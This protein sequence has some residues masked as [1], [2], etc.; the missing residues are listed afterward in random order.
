MTRCLQTDHTARPADARSRS[1]ARRSSS[2]ATP[3][4]PAKASSPKCSTCRR[5]PGYATGGTI[6]IIAN[7]QI[8]FTT[9]PGD[10]RSTRYASDLAKGFDVP[11]VHV[12]ADDVDACIA[13]VHLGDRFPAHVRPRRDDRSDRL[14]PLRPQRAG[15]ARVH[16]A[17]D[18][19][20]DQVASDRA[21][22]VRR[23]AGR[24]RRRSRRA[25]H[26]DARG[27]RPAR[28]AEAH[29]NVKERGAPQARSTHESQLRHDE[30]VADDRRRARD[31]CCAG[32]TRSSRRPPGFTL[33]QETRAQFERRRAALRDDGEVDWGLAE[34]LAFASLLGEGTP[35]RLT[36]QDTERGT[37]SHRHARA[38][39]R[40]DGREVRPAAAPRRRAGARSRCYNSPLSE[41]ACLGFEYGYST[42][43]PRRSCSG[44]RSSATST[45]ARR[46]SSISSSPP[47]A[48]KWGQTSRLDAAA[49]ARLRR[50]GSR[51]L[52]RAPRALPAALGRRATSGSRTA[53]PPR[54]TSICCARRRTRTQAFPLVVMTPK[55]LLR[56]RAAY[57]TLDD[58][59]DGAFREVIDDPR[60]SRRERDTVERAAAVQ[61]QDLLTISPR[62]TTRDASATAR[63]TK[64]AIVR[65]ELLSPLPDA[66][67]SSTLIDELPERRSA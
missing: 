30:A 24:A 64:T 27:A 59:V 13:A 6:H 51:A 57:G 33:K 52:E 37:F 56:K 14:P 25:G 40:E 19:R 28:I 7:N 20:R 41:Y 16:A 23:E 50:R 60:A 46:S 2:T 66:T 65:V 43:L 5:S 17:A 38:A 36:G 32:P 29:R 4:S 34:G 61:R 15:R 22:A 39:R 18:V 45:T 31:S 11:I 53:R 42:E 9:D 44:K 47:G 67:R 48:A 62:A 8:G 58:L 54:N 3:R 21:R 26:G 10:G 55:R 63:S 49:A 35:I 12:N 1:R